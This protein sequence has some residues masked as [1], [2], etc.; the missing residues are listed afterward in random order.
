[1]EVEA[2]NIRKELE[3]GAAG[4]DGGRR[5]VKS[6]YRIQVAISAPTYPKQPSNLHEII[7]ACVHPS[8]RKKDL[9]CSYRKPSILD[10]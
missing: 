6:S 3:G 2:G 4:I 10:G 1:M 7:N 9:H 5:V 8:R